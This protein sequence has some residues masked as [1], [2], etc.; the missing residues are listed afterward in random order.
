MSVVVS[1][2]YAYVACSFAGLHV[3][4]VSNP[5]MP[6]IVGNVSTDEARDV[7]VAG[8]FAYVAAGF[9]LQVVDVSNPA[10][11][12]M[13]GST[14]TGFAKRIAVSG[15]T[16]CIVNQF[17]MIHTVD[18]SNPFQPEVVGTFGM[19]K[20]P[21]GVAM[22]GEYAYVGIR[23]VNGA[24]PSGF[25]V[26]NVSSPRSPEPVSQ[27][28]GVGIANGVALA[29]TKAYLASGPSGLIALDVSD[30]LSLSLLWIVDDTAGE[31]SDVVVSGNYAYVAQWTI[32]LL[33]I[34]ISIPDPV[35]VG[36]LPANQVAEVALAGNY[37]Y[38]AAGTSDLLVVDV[39][40]P[41]SPV[42]VG[43]AST[44][45]T[46]GNVAVAGNYAYVTDV[47]AGLTIVD[48]S[49]PASPVVTASLDPGAIL[50]VVVEGTYAYV[51]AYDRGLQ[52]IDVSNPSAPFLVST[53]DTPLSARAVTISGNYA[54]VA[55]E[56]ALQVVDI[57]N[58]ASMFIQGSAM[59]FQGSAHT[60][61]TALAVEGEHVYLACMFGFEGLRIFPAQC[62]ATLAIGDPVGAVS[63]SALLAQNH[64]NPFARTTSISFAMPGEAG[65]GALEVYD[66]LGRLVRV[67]AN[68]EIPVGRHEVTW[69]GRDSRG[70]RVPSGVYFY[71][72]TAGTYQE[73][74]KMVVLRAP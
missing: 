1:G 31:A 56:Y 55:D 64:P 38:V 27:I 74:K 66:A 12:Y 51:T 71:R 53:V 24:N 48:V 45:G 59:L 20:H 65:G 50:D 57:S 39:S 19:Q 34:D 3:I 73:E 4:D 23:G 67:L 17:L 11:P 41:E 14:P 28:S 10:F 40:N 5:T 58:P 44:P 9:G 30:P 52:V 37:A 63:P 8:N 18:I 21:E 36:L 60:E 32:G 72:L 70:A 29:G 62:T 7:A 25:R 54:Y 69:D 33:V 13:A 68:G 2:T 43:S 22:A 47:T 46:P 16:A 35:I 26:L 49:N 61:I 42:V 15:N 6:M